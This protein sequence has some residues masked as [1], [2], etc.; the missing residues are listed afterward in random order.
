MPRVEPVTFRITCVRMTRDKVA[1]AVT[2]LLTSFAGAFFSTIMF[3]GKGP[4]HDK[5]TSIG[6]INT[7]D[8]RH[9]R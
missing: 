5:L 4:L 2:S 8:T 1:M 9:K 3:G 7:T 6:L